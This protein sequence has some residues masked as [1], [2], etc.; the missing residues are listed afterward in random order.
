M[1]FIE[2]LSSSMKR[3]LRINLGDQEIVITRLGVYEHKDWYSWVTWGPTE[4]EIPFY[5]GEIV[6]GRDIIQRIN[7]LSNG[8][9][10]GDDT[11]L[12]LNHF[13]GLTLWQNA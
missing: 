3:T 11:R 12:Q 8:E 4:V 2:N 1:N 5:T 13:F 10:L 9:D 7:L 6:T